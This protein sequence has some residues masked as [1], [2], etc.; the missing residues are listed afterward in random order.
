MCDSRL[1]R[2][3]CLRGRSSVALTF[4]IIVTLFLAPS[5]TFIENHLGHDSTATGSLGNGFHCVC[6]VECWPLV[7]LGLKSLSHDTRTTG[8]PVTTWHSAYR[9]G[10]S[11]S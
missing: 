5:T 10:A 8:S 11:I 4:R 1:T 3:P 6:R 2:S 7:S 9:A